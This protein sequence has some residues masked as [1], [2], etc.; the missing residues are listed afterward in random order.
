MSFISQGI[1]VNLSKERKEVSLQKRTEKKQNIQTA[2]SENI[3]NIL[4]YTLGDPPLPPQNVIKLFIGLFQPTFKEGTVIFV[5]GGPF[6]AK[7][8]KFQFGFSFEASISSSE[9]KCRLSNDN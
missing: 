1:W 3:G 4:L 5:S 7:T 8:I 2:P 6:R 9:M